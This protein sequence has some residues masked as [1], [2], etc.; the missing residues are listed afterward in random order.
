MRGTGLVVDTTKEAPKESP[1]GN[2]PRRCLIGGYRAG[3]TGTL[4]M[5][6]TPCSFKMALTDED[7]EKGGLTCP[8]CGE[9]VMRI[10]EGFCPA[11][12]HQEAAW[13]RFQEL[14]HKSNL[15]KAELAE[16][17]ELQGKIRKVKKKEQQHGHQHLHPVD[18]GGVQ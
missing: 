12:Y 18:R 10:I 14:S 1:G 8:R 6:A 13:R 11:C 4:I 9:V 16:L 2:L 17:A 5:V 3:E 15:S 7:W